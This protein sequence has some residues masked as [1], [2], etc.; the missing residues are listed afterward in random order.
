MRDGAERAQ[1]AV[2]GWPTRR[3]G[4][5]AVPGKQGS[6]CGHS[7]GRKGRAEMGPEGLGTKLYQTLRAPPYKEMGSRW[8]TVGTPGGLRGNGDHL[9]G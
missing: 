2:L 9:T 6:R 7:T 8:S 3:Q 1:G 5:P 4:M